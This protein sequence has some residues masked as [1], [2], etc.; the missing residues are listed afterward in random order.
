LT[1]QINEILFVFGARIGGART[2]DFFLRAKT[3]GRFDKGFFM[4]NK[5]LN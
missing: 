2:K 4:A 5:T 3:K 1:Q